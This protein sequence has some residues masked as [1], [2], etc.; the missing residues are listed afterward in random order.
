MTPRKLPPVSGRFIKGRSGNP[1]G[2]PKR[3]R[4]T[5]LLLLAIK[6]FDELARAYYGK[7][8]AARQLNRI[9]KVFNEK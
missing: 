1:L 7:G 8:D 9:R 6:F 3:L 2:R 4:D 5:E